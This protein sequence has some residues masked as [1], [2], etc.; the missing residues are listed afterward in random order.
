MY[1]ALVDKQTY[2]EIYHP[3]KKF[4]QKNKLNRAFA[5]FFIL[6]CSVF[7]STFVANIFILSFV[8]NIFI[9]PSKPD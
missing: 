6:S 4:C 5:V 8:D 2:F 1:S 3:Q 7:N 9:F